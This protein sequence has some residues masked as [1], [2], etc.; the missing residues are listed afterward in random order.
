M[1]THTLRGRLLRT[2]ALSL[3]L[4]FGA[5][6]L[7]LVLGI[8]SASEQQMLVHLAHDGGAVIEAMEF[9]AHGNPHLNMRS[10]EP[11]YQQPRS[12]SYFEVLIDGQSFVRSLSLDG[13]AL[14]RPDLAG[15]TIVDFRALGPA[16]QQLVV[17]ALTRPV[18]GHA[19]SVFVAEETSTTNS[20]IRRLSGWA[21][22]VLVLLLPAAL[23]LQA[24]AVRR[25]LQPLQAL[26]EELREVAAEQHTQITGEVPL[27]IKPL[28]D[29]INR[30]LVLL[31][32]RMHHSRT[33]LGNLAHALKT[34]LAVLVRAAEQPEV[35]EHIARQLDEQA[36]AI[37]MRLE[38][39]LRRARLAGPAAPGAG[40]HF[41]PATEL[42]GLVQVLRSIHRNKPIKLDVDACDKLLPLDREDMLELV[43]NLAD[44]ACKWARARVRIDAQVTPEGAF[45]LCVAD[46]G[47]GCN[48][49][50]AQAIVGRGTR[51]DESVA[52]HG[53]GLAIVRDI[54]NL[55]GGRLRIA[56]DEA[57][58]GM[59]V[60][61]TLPLHASSVWPG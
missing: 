21:L 43:G 39:E 51:L 18:Q 29:E 56:A 22:L 50:E 11:V 9:D 44:N 8:R 1:K 5:L 3:L 13:M 52:G 46:D 10:V 54:V 40:A 45:E 19:I 32:M 49:S 36:S 37:R 35:P 59:G 34:P 23:W 2:L 25:A 58:G 20:E 4:V 30:L 33:A 31:Q 15:A 47:P 55:Y 26:R 57:Y 14:A 16:Q 38:R 7:L 60:R 27:E 17:L 41:N 6:L 24:L 61:V 12:G 48:E 53:L 28:V 42:P